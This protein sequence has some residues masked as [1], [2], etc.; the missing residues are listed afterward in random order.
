MVSCQP[1]WRNKMLNQTQ[2]L[3]T[4][5]CLTLIYQTLNNLFMGKR[6]CTNK[7]RPS[8]GA[9]YPSSYAQLPSW[10]KGP[11]GKPEV[12]SVQAGRRARNPQQWL[13]LIPQAW[14]QSYSD[15]LLCILLALLTHSPPVLEGLALPGCLAC[16]PFRGY[17]GRV[18][19]PSLGAG[20]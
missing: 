8:G 15:L 4:T 12:G 5:L 1:H 19:R 13:D 16:S 11:C 2:Q 18:E 7:K 10:R 20:D 17:C 6:F 14:P 9:K 3:V